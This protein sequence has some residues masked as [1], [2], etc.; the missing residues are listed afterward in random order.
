VR[1]NYA[2]FGPTLACEELIERRQIAVSN[3]TLRKWMA[4]AGLWM[5]R[6]ERKV[7]VSNSTP[8]AEPSMIAA[9]VMRSYSAMKGA[10]A[11][12]DATP[13]SYSIRWHTTSKA[14]SS[15]RFRTL[16]LGLVGSSSTNS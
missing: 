3:E 11:I 8:T 5:S 7:A 16:P 15:S 4:D 1:E 6:R 14:P 9:P 2:D 10:D 12:S 13:P